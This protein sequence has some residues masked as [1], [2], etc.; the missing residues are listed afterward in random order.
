[1]LGM[2]GMQNRLLAALPDAIYGRIRD[3]LEEVTLAPG[4]IVYEA[5]APVTHA[6]F[7]HDAVVS[8]GHALRDGRTVSIAMIG[9][10]GMLGVAVVLGADNSPYRVQVQSA[11]R[12][13]R[14]KVERLR[15]QFLRSG[16]FEYLML[17]YTQALLAQVAQTAVCNRHHSVEQ[18][19][20]RWLLMAADRIS[21]DSLVGTH[22]TIAGLLGVR[23][24]GIT[25]AA[26]RL[27][28][29][30][31][32]QYNRGHITLRDRNALELHACECYRVVRQE[33]DRLL[34]SPS[35]VRLE[36]RVR[37]VDF[38]APKPPK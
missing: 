14:I 24:E 25:E 32:I 21:G 4:D 38:G 7:L 10:E 15:E 8:L 6:Y 2:K 37:R 1:M 34:P 17:R 19:L 22:E 30:R 29:A 27:Q 3:H 33:F 11:G 9:N 12:A 36:T 18:Q 28:K 20:C 5:Q 35:P 26:R 23:R 13:S 16:P 31:V